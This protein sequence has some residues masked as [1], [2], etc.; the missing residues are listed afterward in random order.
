MPAPAVWQGLKYAAAEGRVG[1]TI[2]YA[3]LVLGETGPSDANPVTLGAV[4]GALRQVGL[5]S[6]ARA[7]AL[8]AMLARTL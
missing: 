6:D 7:I 4:V 1:E 8:E 5:E 2:I 3:L